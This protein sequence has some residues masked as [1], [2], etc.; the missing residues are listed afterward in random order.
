MNII[1]LEKSSGFWQTVETKL[2]QCQRKFKASSFMHKQM[3]VV[4]KKLLQ[5]CLRLK[6]GSLCKGVEILKS[7]ALKKETADFLSSNLQQGKNYS[8]CGSESRAAHLQN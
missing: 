3:R 5:K 1:I 6:L 7:E 2:C 8:D 4:E